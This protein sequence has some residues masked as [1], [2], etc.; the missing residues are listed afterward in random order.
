MRSCVLS[1]AA[2]SGTGTQTVT[3][4]ADGGGSFI[5]KLFIFQ[6][7][8]AAINTLTAG[9]VAFPWYADFRGVDTGSVR[10]ARTVADC[11]S[12]FN[13]KPSGTS[14]SGGDA[15]IIDQ[16]TDNFGTVHVERSAKIS[17]IRSGEFDILYSTNNRT[18]DSLLVTVFG[19]DDIDFTFT[20]YTSGTY[21]TPSKPQGLLALNVPVPGSSGSIATGTGGQNIPWGFATRDGVY[22]TDALYV[23]SQGNN[24]SAQRTDGWTVDLDGGAGTQSSRPTV[25]AWADTTFTIAN[26]S[27]AVSQPIAISGDL[28]QTAAGSFTQ[29]LATGSQTIT[30]GFAIKWLLTLSTGYAASSS[31]QSPIGQFSMGWASSIASQGGFWAGEKT[32]GNVGP[33]FGARYIS[34]D[35]MVRFATPNGASTTFNSVASLTDL[36]DDAGTFTMTW[37]SVGGTACEVLWFAIGEAVVPPPPPPEPVFRTREVVR[38]RLRRA[39][40]VWNEK[41]GLQ[42]RV[43]INLFAVDMQP[44]VGTADTPDPLVMIRASKDGGFTWG[45]ERRLTA[46]RVGEFFNRIN[47]WQWGQ[48]R[49][50]VFEVSCTDPVLWN[51]VGAYFDAEGGDN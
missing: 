18:G 1:F 32:N 6:S 25:S 45:N 50:W 19:G 29:P 21:T 33:A 39:P 23:V 14:E 7:G 31:T 27:A 26:P 5:G 28:I 43:R 34:D 42:T 40:I 16:W 20:N 15:S 3:G 9:N 48:G 30:V 47:A 13:F 22:G 36:D 12:I 37:D 2:R 10:S 46:G 41:G 44:G 35:S 17:A 51:L 49:D 38:R 4:V 11:Y 24:W 8:Y